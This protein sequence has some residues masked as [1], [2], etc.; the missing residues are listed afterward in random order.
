MIEIEQPAAIFLY[1]LLSAV[2]SM[3][4]YLFSRVVCGKLNIPTTLVFFL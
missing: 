2:A 3:I 4:Q 1:L